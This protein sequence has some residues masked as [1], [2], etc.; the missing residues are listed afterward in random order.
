MPAVAAAF[1]LAGCGSGTPGQAGGAPITPDHPAP[2][3]IAANESPPDEI[4]SFLDMDFG[5]DQS[6]KL[7]VSEP[8]YI[9][10][11]SSPPDGS[12]TVSTPCPQPNADEIAKLKT[13]EEQYDEAIKPAAGTSPEVVA[14]L[15]L[16]AN[17]E[18][19]F[20]AWTT[21]SGDACWEVDEERPD[22][23]G[24]GGPSGPCVAAA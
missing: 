5:T 3:I 7:G 6:S 2:P 12:S 24:G 13:E 16:G 14:K 15:E 10:E 21:S 8:E 23:S 18:L 17:D 22:G 20:T 1:V 19:F 11:Q 4:Q 9:C